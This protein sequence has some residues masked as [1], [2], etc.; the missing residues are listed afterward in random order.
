MALRCGSP[1]LPVFCTRNADGA[2]TLHVDPIVPM[3]KSGNL[4]RDLRENTE[5]I[6]D[7]MEA[8][9]RRFPEQWFWFHKRWKRF[10]PALYP[11]YQEKRKRKRQ[12][13]MREK[14]KMEGRC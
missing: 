12:R 7:A 5:R 8:G 1:V 10:Y 4:R 3:E 6:T 2:L 11:E 9:V 14:L 13:E